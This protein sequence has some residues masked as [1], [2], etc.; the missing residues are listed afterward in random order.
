MIYFIFLLD[1]YGIKFHLAWR[2]LLCSCN[3]IQTLQSSRSCE[4]TTPAFRNLDSNQVKD[5]RRLKRRT[6][7]RKIVKNTIRVFLKISR[8]YILKEMAET[9]FTWK[10]QLIL[11]RT[12][13][14]IK[15]FSALKSYVSTFKIILLLSCTLEVLPSKKFDYSLK[16]SYVKYSNVI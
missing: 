9:K 15:S 7:K 4:K 11:K 2:L 6:E 16:T 5:Y 14:F 10:L 12:W 1:S 8:N 3:I 13:K